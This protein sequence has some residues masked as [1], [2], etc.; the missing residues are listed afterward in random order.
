MATAIMLADIDVRRARAFQHLSLVLLQLRDHLL[1]VVAQRTVDVH[2]GYA[3]FVDLGRVQRDAVVR[4][5]QHFAE[6][7]HVD[8]PRSRRAQVLLE[9]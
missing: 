1:V 6:A 4:A 5:R 2:E 7:P 3:P 8:P 9:I